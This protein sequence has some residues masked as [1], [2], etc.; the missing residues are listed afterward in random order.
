MGNSALRIS[1]VLLALQAR[2]P[3]GTKSIAEALYLRDPVR[4]LR[5]AAS[6]QKLA[7]N[8]GQIF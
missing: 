5:G 3:S 7:A 1:S 4:S 6:L 8:S 2:E